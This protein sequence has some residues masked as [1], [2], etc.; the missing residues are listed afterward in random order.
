MITMEITEKIYKLY[1]HLIFM[2]NKKGQGLS[3]TTIILLVLGLVILVMLILG[4]SLGWNKIFP[5]LKSNNVQTIVNDCSIACSTQAKF[6]FCSAKRDLNNGEETIVDVTC[7]QLSTD[8]EYEIYGIDR[9]PALESEC[10][11]EETP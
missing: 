7:Y 4:F 10:V 1:N 5:F 11:T 3:T 9:C 6:D 2:D 8:T